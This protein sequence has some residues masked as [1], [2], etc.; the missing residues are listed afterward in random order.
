[1]RYKSKMKGLIT[2]FL[3]I[4]FCLTWHSTT[5]QNFI[6]ILKPEVQK[7]HRFELASD[8]ISTIKI[9]MSFAS[10]KTNFQANA[11]QKLLEFDRVD[12]IFT[13]YPLD[14]KQWKIG[15]DNLLQTRFQ[16]LQEIF[17]QALLKNNTKFRLLIQTDCKT[18]SQ[19]KGLFHGFILYPNQ[20]TLQLSEPISIDSIPLPRFDSLELE[21]N[22]TDISN[23]IS[24]ASI[25]Q[26][27]TAIQIFERHPEWKDALVVIDWTASMYRQGALLI[28]W[29][30]QH[31]HENRIRHFV[32]F[33]D[34]D[35]KFDEDKEIGS[36][37]GIYDTPADTLPIMWP[38]ILAVT[39]GG[40]GGDHRENDIEALLEGIQRCPECKSII[41]I[42]DNTGPIRD[43]TL[44]RSL[45]LPIKVLLCRAYNDQIEPD[46]L[47]LADFSKGS[48]HTKDRD[49]DNIDSLLQN[50]I[51]TIGLESYQR[52]SGRFQKYKPR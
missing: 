43:L 7:I 51:L 28:A 13:L 14:P 5:A 22:L 37:G 50:N 16:K 21:K 35:D 25:L 23:I 41:L 3:G 48:L 26:D 33:N 36:T 15:Y 32:F 4:I 24:G 49:L 40:E 30:Q 1:M 27:S 52:V 20:K 11:T 34:G 42:A 19:A 2:C 17:P 45:N 46:Y 8:S 9:P 6:D 39:M 18:L 44:I 47:T 12:L 29:Q 38:I 31:R 10:A